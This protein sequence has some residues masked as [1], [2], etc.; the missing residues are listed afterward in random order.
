MEYC[1]YGDESCH[2][3]NDGINS[4]ALGCTWCEKEK[5]DTIAREL[6]DLK[7]KHG[8]SPHGYELKWTSVSPSKIDY[9]ID[10]TNYFLGNPL[11]NYRAVLVPDKTVL[12]H[13]KFDQTHS[14]WLYKLWYHCVKHIITATN[15]YNIYI[16]ISERNSYLRSQKLKE[17][18]ENRFRENHLPN[19][20]I[21]NVQNVDSQQVEILQLADFL[22]GALCYGERGLTGSTTKLEIV[23]LLRE[24]LKMASWRKTLYAETKFSILVW[25]P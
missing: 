3:E 14:E 20:C 1:L 16:D 11:L 13:T 25:N 5:K 7:E 10:V 22:T 21:G 12:T 6:R 15:V 8:L 9:F 2:L 17:V 18:L 24:Y 19:G 23:N 4:M